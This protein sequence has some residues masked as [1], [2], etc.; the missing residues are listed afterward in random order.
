MYDDY[1]EENNYSAVVYLTYGKTG[2]LFMGD[3]ESK[4]E[5]DL[6][7]MGKTPDVDVIKIGHHGSKTSSGKNF[8]NAVKPEH[9]VIT[10]G[11]NSYG[12]PDK[13]T[14]DLLNEMKISSYRTDLMGSVTF[15]S[16]GGKVELK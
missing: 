7:D 16:D 1:G 15:V 8:I 3:A 13:K 5:N 4:V 6:I 14:T 12:H 11:K 9:A 2:F 10:T